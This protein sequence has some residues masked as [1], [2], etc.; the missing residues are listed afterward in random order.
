MPSSHLAKIDRAPAD[1]G[2]LELAVPRSR[3]YRFVKFESAKGKAVALAEIEFY[4]PA[5]RLPGKPFGTSGP[6]GLVGRHLPEGFRRRSQD[7]VRG[8]D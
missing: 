1:D 7:L 5:G 8:P 2:W 4:S 3:V 6:Q